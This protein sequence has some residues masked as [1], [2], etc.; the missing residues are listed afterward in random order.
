MCIVRQYLILITPNILQEVTTMP[1][2]SASM[3]AAARASRCA[4]RLT[5]PPQTSPHCR[6][7]LTRWSHHRALPQPLVVPHP[8]QFLAQE[9]VVGAVNTRTTIPAVPPRSAL[10]ENSRSS[11]ETKSPKWATKK[12]F[13]LFEFWK[14]RLD[15]IKYFLLDSC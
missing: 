2:A 6:R 15:H 9:E 14:K 11:D 7:Q 10:H 4:W 8:V 12:C 5:P 3:S 1:M 13:Y